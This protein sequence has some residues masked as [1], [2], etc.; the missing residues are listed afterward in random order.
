MIYYTIY[1]KNLFNG[2]GYIDVALENDLLLKDYVQF[3]D[4]GMKPRRTYNIA[5]PPSVRGKPGEFVINLSEI[6]AITT[7]NP[8]S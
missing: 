8:P 6:A 1:L 7:T 2:T 5:N 4:I 3:L